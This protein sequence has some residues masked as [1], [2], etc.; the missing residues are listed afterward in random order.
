[1]EKVVYILGAGFSYPFGL[2]LVNNFIQKAKDYYASHS[3]EV[4]YFQEI[5]KLQDKLAKIKNSYRSNLYNFEEVLS[6]LEMQS[7]FS[8]EELET[9]YTEFIRDVISHY[10][11]EFGISRQEWGYAEEALDF[12]C[13]KDSNLNEFNHLFKFLAGLCNKSIVCVQDRSGHRLT[14]LVDNPSD[15]SYR[16]I[17]LNYDRMI[18]KASS[19]LSSWDSA[20]K[21]VFL[22]DLD[23]SEDY[24]QL[25]LIKI[26]GCV[27]AGNIIPPTWKKGANN[28]TV[29][30]L[31]KCAY[32]ALG[33]ANHI[34]VIG[35]SLPESDSYLKYLLKTSFIG[36]ENLKSF[37]VVCYDPDNSVRKRY[38]SFIEFPNFRFVS[39]KTEQYIDLKDAVKQEDYTI[40]QYNIPS[41][42]YKRSFDIEA[43]HSRFFSS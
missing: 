39:G 8:G 6:L 34:R 29:S 35:F 21:T 19:C 3:E 43:A 13:G 27:E 26:H 12:P 16:I 15:T 42:G 37:D 20:Y 1:M 31:W 9:K 40:L 41:T 4:A 33:E 18:E 11:P 32:K 10:T 25:R 28:T 24:D 36:S 23:S 5:F 30:K 22:E 2:P 7:F 14:Q 17:S 38:E